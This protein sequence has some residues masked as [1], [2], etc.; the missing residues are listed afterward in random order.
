M[1]GNVM[2]GVFSKSMENMLWELVIN[3]DINLVHNQVYEMSIP[4]DDL[5]I[6]PGEKVNL[7]ILTGKSGVVDEII[8]KDRPV[9]FIRP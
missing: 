5:N 6:K 9:S 2:P 3:H 1:R 7:T 4:F 8:T